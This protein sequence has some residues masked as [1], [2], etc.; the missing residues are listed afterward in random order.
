MHR[1][2]QDWA[3]WE[4]QQLG[5]FAAGHM[6]LGY[7]SSISSRYVLSKC[8]VL[9]SFPAYMRVAQF[10]AEVCWPSG[11]LCSCVWQPLLGSD[12]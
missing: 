1:A 6:S 3:G 12:S 10:V 11:S 4:V 9:L 8:L 2:M 5:I 7:M